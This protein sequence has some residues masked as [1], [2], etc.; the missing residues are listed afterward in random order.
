VMA[1][2]LIKENSVLINLQNKKCFKKLEDG[3]FA[4][5]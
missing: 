3:R 2:R 1:Q 5:V 4:L